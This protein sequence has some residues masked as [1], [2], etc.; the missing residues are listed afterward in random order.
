MSQDKRV[1]E[2]RK[3][4][5]EERY[6][7]PKEEWAHISD[8]DY[9][10]AALDQRTRERDEAVEQVRV[11]KHHMSIYQ[12]IT[13]GFAP[14]MKLMTERDTLQAKLDTSLLSEQMFQREKN[15]ANERADTLQARL[16]AAEGALREIRDYYR[17]E[18]RE[19]DKAYQAVIVATAALSAAAPSVAGQ[20]W[21]QA[22]PQVVGSGY[23]PET[24]KPYEDNCPECAGRGWV[25]RSGRAMGVSDRLSCAVC[26]GT[27]KVPPPGPSSA[28]GGAPGGEG[29]CGCVC[30]EPSCAALRRFLVPMLELN[31]NK[32][33]AGDV[34]DSVVWH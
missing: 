10:L 6:G 28:A 25:W 19:G 27:G 24:G 8:I 31:K 30:A 26:R 18:F 15:Q 3:R 5:V 34:A 33:E 4:N 21:P 22:S 32:K 20:A 9:L 2:I 17:G 7:A 29:G 23:N 14:N 11:W 13:P 16:T 12:Q 1:E